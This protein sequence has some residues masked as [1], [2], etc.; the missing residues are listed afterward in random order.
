M[1]CNEKLWN[2]CRFGA[3]ELARSVE[4]RCRGDPELSNAIIIAKTR[5][6]IKPGHRSARAKVWV[7]VKP[8]SVFPQNTHSPRAR[9][10]EL[11][12]SIDAGMVAFDRTRSPLW[13]V[14]TVFQNFQYPGRGV[15]H[16]FSTLCLPRGPFFPPVAQFLKSTEPPQECAPHLFCTGQLPA[17]GCQKPRVKNVD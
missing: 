13:R 15:F 5:P 9:R 1:C 4:T 2:T 3:S 16:K 10:S 7:A 12:H 6:T 17:R 14:S 8:G 11:R